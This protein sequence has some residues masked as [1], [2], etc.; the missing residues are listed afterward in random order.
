[1]SDTADLCREHAERFEQAAM[2]FVEGVAQIQTPDFA[3]GIDAYSAIQQ[4]IVAAYSAGLRDAYVTT[5]AIAKGT[6]TQT[7]QPRR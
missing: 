3:S 7:N 5:R 2:R 1:M 4:A 6:E